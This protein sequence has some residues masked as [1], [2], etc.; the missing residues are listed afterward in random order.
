MAYTKLKH[1][2]T[3]EIHNFEFGHAQNLLK[4]QIDNKVPKEQCWTNA[5]KNPAKNSAKDKADDSG[6]DST[7][8]VTEEPKG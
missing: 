8:K 1:P 4:L 6:S 7:T 3:G 2:T 5:E